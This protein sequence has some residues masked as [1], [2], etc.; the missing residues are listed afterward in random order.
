MTNL[1][2]DLKRPRKALGYLS[3]PMSADCALT[4]NLYHLVGMETAYRLWEAGV[5]AISPHANSPGVGRTDLSCEDWMAIDL[6]ILQRCDWILMGEGWEHSQGCQ[7][8]FNLAMNLDIKVLFT[9]DEAIE[10]AQA[11]EEAWRKEAEQTA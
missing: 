9:L 6:E 1:I 8:E 4:R 5:A 7:R 10:Y 2:E 3:G 11:L